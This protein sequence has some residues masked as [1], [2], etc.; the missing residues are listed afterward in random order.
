MSN[1]TTHQQMDK[2]LNNKVRSYIIQYVM[3]IIQILSLSNYA[4]HILLTEKKFSHLIHL[5]KGHVNFIFL[6]PYSLRV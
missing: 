4:L 5:L 1:K 3:Q 6:Q 2:P